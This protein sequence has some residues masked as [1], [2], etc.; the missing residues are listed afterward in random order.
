MDGFVDTFESIP[1]RLL[2]VAD[3]VQLRVLRTHHGAVLTHQLV[4]GV[5]VVPYRLPM[6]HATVQLGHL[7]VERGI[8]ATS[9]TR[10]PT[11]HRLEAGCQVLWHRVPAILDLAG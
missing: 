6:Q 10:L 2:E 1:E 8:H 7:R 9:K 5:A 4:T 3:P 11:A